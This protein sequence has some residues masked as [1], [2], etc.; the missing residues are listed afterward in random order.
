MHRD[1]TFDRDIQFTSLNVGNTVVLN[2]N[3]LD[4]DWQAGFRVIGRY[5][6]CPLSVVE[7][8]YT[9]IFDWET[10]ARCHDPTGNLYSLFSRPRQTPACSAPAQ[11]A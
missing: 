1:V 10:R 6:I 4:F 3:Q 5:D 11:R 8:G 7:F 2:S 9:G